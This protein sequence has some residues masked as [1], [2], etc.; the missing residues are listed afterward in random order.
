[1]KVLVLGAGATGSVL[2]HFLC[3]NEAIKEVV[4]G[5]INP[6]K[7]RKFLRS[8]TKLTFKT[9]DASKKESILSHLQG[10]ALVINATM[11]E[12]NKPIMDA[13]LE[14]GA[15]YQDL[16]SYYRSQAFGQLNYLEEYHQKFSQ[17]GIIGILDASASPGVTNLMAAE[18]ASKFSRVDYIRIKLLEDVNSDT[19][20]T[21]WSKEIAF[22]EFST[23]PMVWSYGK[24]VEKNFF[25]EEESFD[26]PEPFSNQKCY[27]VAQEEV[28]SLS[29]NIKT[30]Y[31]DIKICG[32]EIQIA[33]SLFKLGLMKRRPIAVIGMASAISPPAQ[34]LIS[35]Y[36]FLIKAWPP[37]LDPGQ[38]IKLSQSGKLHNAHFWASVIVGGIIGGKKKAYK[39]YILFPSQS[40]INKLYPGAN[41]ISY[42]AGL[43]AAVFATF[44]PSINKKGILHPESLDKDTRKSILDKLESFG[45]KIEVSEQKF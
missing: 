17:K 44:M 42:A 19:P 20:F 22:D 38:M 39:S 29:K 45:V 43:T 9:I 34:F 13:A 27:L 11:P 23:K 2:A 31:A 10:C 28:G 37:I 25:G 4:C 16:A 26:F 32:S 18:L 15:N 3:A 8:S 41:Y 21:A 36:N 7:A 12:F 1:M 35:P 40:E 24:F 14:A 6:K 33:K 5:D 30:K